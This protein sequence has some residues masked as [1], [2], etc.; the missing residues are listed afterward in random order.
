MLTHHDEGEAWTA[1]SRPLPKVDDE[2]CFLFK[3]ELKSKSNSFEV[4]GWSILEASGGRK[5]QDT[6]VNKTSVE[7]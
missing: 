7:L 4:C 5:Q 3:Q 1:C 2:G 6:G